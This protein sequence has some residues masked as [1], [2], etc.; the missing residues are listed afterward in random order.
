MG[1][2]REVVKWVEE[3]RNLSGG[4]V[5]EGGGEGGELGA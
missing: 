2:G 4:M 5:V 1:G 3:E